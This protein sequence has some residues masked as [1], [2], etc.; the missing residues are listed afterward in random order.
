MP[1]I[2][3][4]PS[5][6]SVGQNVKDMMDLIYFG[7]DD[8]SSEMQGEFNAEVKDKFENV[9]IKDA[10]D[11]IK[12]YRVEVHL[13][14]TQEEDYQTWLIGAGWLK[15][16]LTMQLMM[17]DKEKK[18][19]FMKVFNAAKIQYPNAFKESAVANEG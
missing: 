19:D 4:Y 10:Y 8:D 14:D 18:D 13:E 1:F 15:M 6:L 3:C 5:F 9:K 17:M 7:Y 2:V 16:S 11:D 12:G